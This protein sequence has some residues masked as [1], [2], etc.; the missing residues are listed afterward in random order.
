MLGVIGVEGEL[1][2]PLTEFLFNAF[3]SVPAVG[4]LI[5]LMILDTVTGLMVAA[6]QRKVCSTISFRGFIRKGMMLLMVAT[7][8]VLE[9]I[10]IRLGVGEFEALPFG[11]IIAGFFCFTE[12]LSII[13][14]A[15]GIGVPIPHFMRDRVT[16]MR[17]FLDPPAPVEIKAERVEIKTTHDVEMPKNG[18]PQP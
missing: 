17:N 6:Y 9:T 18:D 8:I 2:H 4:G 1:V 11:K 15:E 13:E 12:V 7:A 16:K 10:V 3:Q 14:N 5:A